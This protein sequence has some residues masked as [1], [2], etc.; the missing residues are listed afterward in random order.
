MSMMIPQSLPRRTQLDLAVDEITK[1]KTANKALR[2]GTDRQH[3][4]IV[5]LKEA[6]ERLLEFQNDP[7]WGEA[8]RAARALLNRK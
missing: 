6:I 7:H 1:L 3:K 4:R 8:E 2:R 5:E